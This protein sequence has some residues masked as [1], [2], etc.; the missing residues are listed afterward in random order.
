MCSAW[1]A[2]PVFSFYTY[3]RTNRTSP[4]TVN[5]LVRDR[6]ERKPGTRS[7]CRKTR[8]G[9]RREGSLLYHGSGPSGEKSGMSAAKA[10]ED[11]DDGQGTAQ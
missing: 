9:T 8:A 6:Y 4:H 5:A 3:F 7:R 11:L 10:F 2:H 1:L